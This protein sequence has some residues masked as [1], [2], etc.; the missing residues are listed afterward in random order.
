VLRKTFGP[1]IWTLL[2]IMLE[3]AHDLY[4]PPDSKVSRAAVGWDCNRNGEIKNGYRIS[5]WKLLE[6]RSLQRPI[7]RYEDKMKMSIRKV[8]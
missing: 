3:G 7:R 5:V 6:G 1:K 8:G 2:N 4:K